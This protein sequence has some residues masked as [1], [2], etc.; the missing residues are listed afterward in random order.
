MLCVPQPPRFR[1]AAWPPA[2]W[3]PFPFEAAASEAASS[4]AFTVVINTFKRRDLL[5]R[6]VAHYATCGAAVASIRV[7][8][9]EQVPPP[10]ASNAADAAAYFAPGRP[11]LVR[12][13]AHPTTSLNNRFVPLRGG[14]PTPGLFS[15]DDDMVV[16]CAALADAF[17]AWRAAPHALVGFYPRLHERRRCGFAYVSAE[18]ALLWRRRF[19]MVL[20]KAAFVHRYYFEL[21]TKHMPAEIR[22]YTTQR[23]ECE[24]LAMAF[25][26]ANASAAPPV[27][28]A[29]P[30]RFWAAAKLDGVGRKGI[31]SGGV[32]G[33][34]AKRGACVEDFR[35]LYGGA[36]PLRVAPLADVAR[37][38]PPA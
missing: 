33:H 7:V 18:P 17:A 23:R 9:S 32:A 10:D 37:R 2:T 8:W 27:W 34:H 12:Y 30:L 29:P 5:R 19:S 1:A 3:A 25:L 21:Y 14:A 38:A 13:E 11:G 36:L 4:S 28:V 16:P 26:V 24:D 22:D 35:D 6:A 15:V 20:T 31:S